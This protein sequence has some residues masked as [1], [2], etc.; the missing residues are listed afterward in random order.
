[1][2]QLSTPNL[3]MPLSSRFNHNLVVLTL[4]ALVGACAP[5]GRTPSATVPDVTCT[6]AGSERLP[7]GRTLLQ[8]YDSLHVLARVLKPEQL[9]LLPHTIKPSLA[10][11]N[12]VQQLLGSMY[13]PALRDAGIQGNTSASVLINTDGTPIHVQVVRSSRYSEMDQATL[14][15]IRSMRFEPAKNGQCPV[16]FFTV[17]PFS[18]TLER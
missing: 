17:I 12:Q 15:V 4:S 14:T 9:I 13:P 7:D 11:R 8:A 2:S 16:P 10:N 1:M 3:L 18:W 6:A 5:G